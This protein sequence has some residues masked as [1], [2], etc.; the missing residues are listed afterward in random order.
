MGEEQA[1]NI[2]RTS[3][4]S[5]DCGTVLT[6]SE[7]TTLTK[8]KAAEQIDAKG[9]PPEQL[10]FRFQCQMCGFRC[11]ISP[12]ELSTSIEL[13]PYSFAYI[14]AYFSP[15]VITQLFQLKVLQWTASPDQAPILKTTGMICPFLVMRWAPQVD[16]TFQ[17]NLVKWNPSP[18]SPLFRVLLELLHTIR[19]RYV[20]WKKT[21]D[22][23]T[24]AML[25]II[26]MLRRVFLQIWERFSHEEPDVF[27]QDIQE[28][29]FIE[30]I[31]FFRSPSIPERPF[32][33]FCQIAEA[34]PPVCRVFP[35][36]RT[37]TPPP[38][39]TDDV[40]GATSVANQQ[41]LLQTNLC[42]PHA[43]ESGDVMTA[44]QFF[45]N[46]GMT[47]DHFIVLGELNWFLRQYAHLLSDIP[48]KSLE[49]LHRTLITH[50]YFSVDFTPDI[51]LFYQSLQAKIR[52]FM[53]KFARAY[54][55]T[56]TDL[57]GVNSE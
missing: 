53:V 52:D 21:H 14:R 5:D 26:H 39:L 41:V 34:R 44:S 35:L 20:Q 47:D 25:V 54:N 8:A 30:M 49:P 6:P 19:K 17:Y 29:L 42:P 36:G 57:N 48:S 31:N 51:F 1:M 38:L 9:V 32:H 3:S 45:V 50:V 16:L 10:T 56:V 18:E 23:E 27:T 40:G 4:S 12:P 11:C 15:E 37:I 2:K 33:A 46:Q 43:F 13:T 55:I 24:Q 7:L 22:P 28:E